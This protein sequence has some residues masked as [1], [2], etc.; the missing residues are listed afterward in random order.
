MVFDLASCIT[1]VQNNSP[2]AYVHQISKE[3]VRA[4]VTQVLPWERRNTFLGARN[5]VQLMQL[6]QSSI[7]EGP[8][9]GRRCADYSDAFSSFLHIVA[10]NTRVDIF[11]FY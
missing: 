4:A 1:G 8:R 10:I 5:V 7:R 11:E 2:A 9:Y 3:S 6:V